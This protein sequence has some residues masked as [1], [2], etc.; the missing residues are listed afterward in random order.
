MK[1]TFLIMVMLAVT[2]STIAQSTLHGKII[3]QHSS[4]PVAGATVVI[5]GNRYAL[6]DENGDFYFKNLKTGSYPV[7][8]S[9]VGFKTLHQTIRVPA[10]A[11]LN[12]KMEQIDLMLQPIEI[13][14]VRAADKA[15]F[16][17]SNLAKK[18][19]EK[20]NTGQD[21][22]FVLNQLPSV[23]VNSDAG[24]GFGYT[25]I[26]I[27]GTDATRINITLNGIPYN[28]AESQGTFF[29]DLPDF[30]SSVNSIQ[31]Q[32]GV[33]TSSNGAGAFGATINMSTNDF[34]E[35]P[36]A[37]SNNSFGSFNTW[38][39]TIK[40]GT[41]LMN[42]HFTVDAR[43]SSL[44]SDGYI[45][46]AASDL[47]SFYLSSAYFSKKY[48]VRFNIFSGKE[49]TYQAWNG[50]PEAMLKTHRTFN[51][52]GTEKPGEPYDNETDNYQQD[53]YQLFYNRDISDRLSF[54]VATFLSRGK[55][56]YEQYKASRKFSDFNLADVAIADSVIKR[57]DVIRQLWLD[58][59]FYGGIFSLQYKTRGTQWITGGGWNRYDGKHY[60]KIVWAQI[61]IPKDYTWYDVDAFKTDAN[62]Y[63]KLQQKI[64][65]RLEAFAD[66]QYR[67]VAYHLN[68]FRD[69]PDLRINNTYNFINPKTGISYSIQNWLAYFSYALANKEPNRDDFEA[70]AT[71]Q[72]RPETLHDLELGVEQRQYEFNWSAT[73]YYMKYFNQL[74]LTGKINDVGAYV[75][76]NIPHSYRMGIELQAG[77]RPAPWLNASGNI[78]LSR[79]KVKDYTAWYDDY[80]NGDQKSETFKERDISF[81]P[82]VISGTVVSFFPVRQW[83]LSLS[84]K[85]VGK[86]YL[87]NTQNEN[88]RLK[89][90]YVQDIRSIY[91]LKDFLF[92]E[93]NLVVQLNNILNKKY[94]PNGYTYSYISGGGMINENYYFP[95]AGRNF[96]IGVNV[97]F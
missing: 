22:P 1:R 95:M 17:K 2:I 60:G 63:T 38:K 36:Y 31:V 15:P 28:D 92:S 76:T 8:I 43:L 9:A 59:Y 11:S 83:E 84:G 73:L 96:M 79:N 42:G 57:T 86:Q 93:I 40:A 88:R 75:R 30:V 20:L 6:S 27:R 16:T 32:R 24:N 26:R 19:I 89:D 51:S 68:G 21:L 29:V 71:Q 65:P 66:V 7:A 77:W 46:R 34:V 74:V 50:V 61:G 52:A 91:T 87:D 41:G 12:F 78:S 13:K 56:Y 18:E 64:T 33:G 69:N 23:V 90:F 39:N 70:G 49:K 67:H 54:N 10:S 37:E 5:S 14:G 62:I 44:K 3:E 81:S 55:G 47:K 25:G 72:P 58:N 80:D 85:Y 45:D 97:K 48:S 94:E 4:Q 35:K 82:S 53:H